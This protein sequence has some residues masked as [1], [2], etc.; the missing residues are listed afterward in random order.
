MTF[1][2]SLLL[3][4]HLDL[5]SL[6]IFQAVPP[7]TTFSD[8]RRDIC[9]K[10]TF[11]TRRSGSSLCFF[12]QQD[13]LTFQTIT[14]GSLPRF[15][16]LFVFLLF[17]FKKRPAPETRF[18]FFSWLFKRCLERM[19]LNFE[20]E[21]LFLESQI[22]FFA[23]LTADSMEQRWGRDQ[24]DE[25]TSGSR[26]RGPDVYGLSECGFHSRAYRRIW[27]NSF[28]GPRRWLTCPNFLT[29][30]SRMV[31]AFFFFLGSLAR[32]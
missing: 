23:F 18:V 29:K 22:N 17:F 28:A 9:V 10:N 3:P 13:V 7:H 32:P 26:L 4:R 1:F 5:H 24:E 6:L 25:G 20:S 31:W 27:R 30:R 8:G 19:P 21:R 15:A 14:L 12:W 11:S 2:L 16:D